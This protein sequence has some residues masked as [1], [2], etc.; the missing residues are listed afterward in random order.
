MATLQES[1]RVFFGRH[2]V[3]GYLVM[4]CVTFTVI[5][6]VLQI[7]HIIDVF[8]ETSDAAFGHRIGLAAFLALVGPM[9]ARRARQR[10]AL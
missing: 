8:P 2:P 1:T 6:L 3:V 4:F 5:S 7:L 9:A 10:D